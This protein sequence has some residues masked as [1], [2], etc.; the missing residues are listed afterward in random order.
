MRSMNLLQILGGVAVAGVVA[1]GAT[2]FTASGVANSITQ[3]ADA[4][5]FLGGTIGQSVTGAEVT[6]IT[7]TNVV[8]GVVTKIDLA[9]VAE[10]M[11][12]LSGHT[13]T[14]LV[15]AAGGTATAVTCTTANDLSFACD[16]AVDWTGISNVAITVV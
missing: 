9:L 12:D 11:T 16:P 3:T 13:V 15:T 5:V 6:G 1:A 7:F 2:A 14:V 10:D 4:S 8:P